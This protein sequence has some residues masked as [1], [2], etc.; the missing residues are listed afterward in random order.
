MNACTP[1]R[2]ELG[3]HVLG[4]LEEAEAAAVRAHLDGC[5]SCRAEHERL[6]GA[7]PLLALARSAPE[8]APDRLRDRVVAAAAQRRSR[9]LWAGAVAA[10]LLLGTVLG[11]VTVRQ[12][13]P[14]AQPVVAVPVRAVEPSDASGWVTFRED[15][16]EVVV[17]IEIEGL[18]PLEEPGVYEAWLYEVD[19][20]IVSIGQLTPVD[21]T[22]TVTLTAEG[23]VERFRG[24]WVTAEPD[25]RDPAQDGPTVV[26]APVPQTR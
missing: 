5:A 20:R 23:P 17:G 3:A 9:R 15:R 4:G 10:A 2:D 25:R 6:A 13:L 21:G 12:L 14:P 7:V 18:E 19:R 11:G 22:V 8:R 1:Y 24:F 26:R 16:G